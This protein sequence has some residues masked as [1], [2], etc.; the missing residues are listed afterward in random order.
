[1]SHLGRSKHKTDFILQ[2]TDVA[3]CLRVCVCV[4]VC[5][6]VSRPVMSDSLG[7]HVL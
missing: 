2:I 1:M 7:D 5:V 6:C 3:S 4:C